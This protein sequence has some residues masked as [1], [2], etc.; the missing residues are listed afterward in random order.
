MF[1]A[2]GIAFT[3]LWDIQV[4]LVL[5][6]GVAIGMTFGALPGLSGNVAIG[7]VLPFTFGWDPAMAMYFFIG[8]VGSVTFAGS[9]PAILLNTPGTPPNAATCFDGFPMA[10]KGQ[11]GKALGISATSSGLGAVFGAVLLIALIP[12]L[13]AIVLSFGAPEF[14]WIV[15]FGL[16]T[17]SYAA[18]ANLLKGLLAGSM[19]VLVS[20]IGFSNATFSMRFTGGT[21]YLHDGVALVPFAVGLFAVSELI[22]YT[23][24]GGSI[25]DAKLDGKIS[26]VM[27]GIKEVFKHKICFFRSAAIG[28]GIGIIP[29]VGGTAAAFMSYTTA[30]QTSKHPETFGTGDPEG[31]IAPEAANDA[32]D[33]GALVPTMT[34]GIPGS[35]IMAMLLSSFILHGMQPGPLL[36]RDNLHI[37]MI[38]IVGLIL[39]NVMTSSVGLLLAPYLAKLVNVR[40]A[41]ISPIILILCATGAYVIRGNIYDVL[42]LG[43]AGFFGYALSRFGYPVVCLVIGYLLGDLAEQNYFVAL[44]SSYGSYAVFFD[45]LISII[46]IALLAVMIVLPFVGLFKKKKGEQQ[47]ETD[48]PSE[49]VKISTK[50]LFRKGSVWFA[51]FLLFLALVFV[52]GAFNYNTLGRTFPLIV[53]VPAIGLALIV[54]LS[55]KYPWLSSRFNMSVD[56]LAKVQEKREGAGKASGAG[57]KLFV[58]TAWITGFIAS[59]FFIGFSITAPIFTFLF[60]RFHGRVSLWKTIIMTVIMAAVIIGFFNT[61]M[62]ADLFK[63]YFF[64]EFLPPL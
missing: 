28:S 30:V 3:S 62:G 25:T 57:R 42:V 11:A 32:K 61:L 40:V 14:F 38:L 13:R 23:L 4:I 16:F 26:G 9:I 2:L 36:L 45:S 55:E 50:G 20:L 27:S 22:R 33:G 24:R 46:L 15:I 48:G 43:I 12:F 54:L 41:Y 21:Y 44:G 31:I 64:G 7:I 47:Q 8:I 10:Q 63:G 6:L 60:L 37:V 49:A 34:F 17:V 18:R 29:G 51:V 5:I 56:S 39:A 19:G 53:G 52:T 59:L 58:I 1:E 35:A